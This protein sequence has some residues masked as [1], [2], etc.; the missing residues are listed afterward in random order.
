MRVVVALVVLC[1]ACLYLYKNNFGNEIYENKEIK[2]ANKNLL[3]MMLETRAESGEY[4]ETTRTNWPT[5]GYIFNESLSKCEQGSSLSWDSTKNTVVMTGNVSDKC[6]VYFNKI[7]VI[8]SEYIKSLYTG[9]QGDNNLYR[10]DST[11]TNG[12]KD[13][14]YRYAGSSDTTNNYLC[15][16]YDVVDGTCKS[17]YRVIGVFDNQVK[18]IRNA[19]GSGDYCEYCD[20]VDADGNMCRYCDSNWDYSDIY[21]SLN[22]NYWNQLDSN[23]QALVVKTSWKNCFN[24]CSIIDDFTFSV[25]QTTGCELYGYSCQYTYNNIGIMS[26]SDY[27]YAAP[28]NAWNRL[29]TYDSNNGYSAVVDNNWLFIGHVTEDHND[30]WTMTFVDSYVFTINYSGAL[31]YGGTAGS[32]TGYRPVMYL[33][34]SVELISGDGTK[35]NPYIIN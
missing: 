10:H 24:N 7:K 8:L 5:T 11:L 6:Y 17:L 25:S 18:I 19:M 15:F 31:S 26:V 20:G 1:G 32:G 3:S 30:E 23:I 33:K 16:S 35:T 2:N 28:P 27:A 14:S 21:I 13:N 34:D 29:L 22:N 9:T 12:A 4:Q